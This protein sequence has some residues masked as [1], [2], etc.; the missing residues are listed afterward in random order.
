MS[1]RPAVTAIGFGIALLAVGVA[2]AAGTSA[3]SAAT[4]PVSTVAGTTATVTG[5]VNPGGESTTWYVEYGTTTGYGKKT[6]VK[7]A[8]SGGGIY[9][10]VGTVIDV[11]DFGA[12]PGTIF[13]VPS[14]DESTTAV[15]WLTE[16]DT[17]PDDSSP[18]SGETL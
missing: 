12:R 10:A 17:G 5:A 14:E 6:S 4:G 3:P 9:V 7:S 2:V 15:V 1:P 11:V 16:D 8:G 18:S 13:Y